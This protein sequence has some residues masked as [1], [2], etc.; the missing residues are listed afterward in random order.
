MVTTAVIFDLDGTL[1]YTIED[2]TTAI[3]KM[4]DKLGYDKRTLEEVLGYINKGARNLVRLSL[5]KSVQDVEF[6]VDS[7]LGIYE[8]EYEECFLEKTKAYEDVI[9]M[10]EHLKDMKVRI[11]VLSNKQ[12]K[13]VKPM[14]EK[15]FGKDTF[16][17][18][19]GQGP[20][21]T[22][23][24]PACALHMCKAMGAKPFR[25]IF[26]GDSDIDIKT[27]LNAEMTAIGV[28]WGYRSVEVLKDAGAH[29]IA[30]CPEDILKIT[31]EIVERNNAKKKKVKA[32]RAEKA[33]SAEQKMAAENSAEPREET[34]QGTE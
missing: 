16:N 29:Y 25:C 24:N 10:L 28:S 32:P 26:V 19:M 22:K 8:E 31:G 7:A 14:I 12:D 18:V 21:P 11:G 15:L 33:T 30:E 20:F 2:I 34:E 1:A 5:P 6:I 9:S 23:P 13:F 27:A 4:L 17:V 3:N